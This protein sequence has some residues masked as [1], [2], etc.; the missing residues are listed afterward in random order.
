LLSLRNPLLFRFISHKLLRLAVPLLL[1]LMLLAAGVTGGTFYR[2]LFWLQIVFYG[3]ALL[4]ALSPS[5]KRFRPVA[6]ANTFV[7]LNAAAALAF[8]NFVAGKRDVW[9]F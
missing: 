3:M 9:A 8:W 1:A 6:I 7:M 5:T 2:T 4:G